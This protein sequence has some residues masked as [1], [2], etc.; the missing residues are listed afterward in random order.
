MDLKLLDTT[1]PVSENPGLNTI[2]PRFADIAGMIQEGKFSDAAVHAQEIIEEQIYDIRIICYFLYGVFDELGPGSLH[3][4][5]NSMGMLFHENWEAIGPSKNRMKHVK[6]SLIWFFKQTN[7]ILESE[8]K[9]DGEK[10]QVWQE[11]TSPTDIQEALEISQNLRQELYDS[12]EKES[13]AVVDGLAKMTAWLDS[14][15]RL[16]YQDPELEAEQDLES[17]SP[18]LLESGSE[19]NN[20]SA[21]T[22]VELIPQKASPLCDSESYPLQMLIKKMAAFEQL[23]GEKKNTGAALI[24]NDINQIINN[25]DPQIYFPDLFSRFSRLFALNVEN[26]FVFDGCRDNVIWQSME[27]LYHVDMES[28]V[29]LDN[30]F[31]VK[32]PDSFHGIGQGQN[33]SLQ[34]GSNGAYDN[35]DPGYH[36]E[37]DDDY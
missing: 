4:I 18:D 8:K 2:D 29:G 24:A 11:N 37:N 21:R 1:F 36:E 10:W 5:F 20:I 12:L 26:L 22:E 34:D 15:Y 7:K 28:F 35:E 3:G 14:F 30:G 33:D 17:D 23:I 19:K 13:T 25:F 27:K 32:T 9:K 16:I 31:H 6:N